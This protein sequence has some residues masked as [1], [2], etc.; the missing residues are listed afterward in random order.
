MRKKKLNNILKDAENLANDI[1]IYM[2]QYKEIENP[3]LEKQILDI[4][5]GLKKDLPTIIHSYESVAK[6]KNKSI[7]K[8]YSFNVAKSYIQ[9]HQK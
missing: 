3:I 1:Q 8:P 2:D 5:R 4:Y 9:N 7:S 6:Q